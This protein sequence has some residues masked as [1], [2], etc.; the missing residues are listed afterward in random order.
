VDELKEGEE[1][2][3]TLRQQMEQH[4]VNPNCATC[5]ARMD[6][7]GFGFENFDAIGAWRTKE[8]KHAID[9]SG[10]LP[11]G[12]KF[13]GPKELRQVLLKKKEAFVKCFAEKLLTYALGR[14]TER[15][16]RCFIEEIAKNA[17]K[18]EYHFTSLVNEIVRS[19][20]FMKKG[21][22]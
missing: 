1:L 3:G 21:K 22:K 5:H 18:N 20:V 14:G 10:I 13:D 17:A 6:P 9:A 15:S 8:G 11:D 16:D 4:R 12:A 19:D 2:K 7:L